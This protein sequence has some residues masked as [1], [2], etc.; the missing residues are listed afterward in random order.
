MTWQP[1]CTC[2]AGV[3]Q[4]AGPCDSWMGVHAALVV[5]WAGLRSSIVKAN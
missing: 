5:L 1:C 2:L 4:S 3:S